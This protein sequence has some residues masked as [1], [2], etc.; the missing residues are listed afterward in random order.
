MAMVQRRKRTMVAELRESHLSKTATSGAELF[1]GDGRFTGPRTLEVALRGGGTRTIA[2]ER[3][4]I[5]VGSRA[6]IPAI[7]DWLKPSR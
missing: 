3:V 5:D 6:S 7:S 1:R 4:F 2:G